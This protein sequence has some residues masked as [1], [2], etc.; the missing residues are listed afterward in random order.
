M[1]HKPTITKKGTELPLTDMK[2]KPYMPV[3]YRLV[4]F[5][6]EHPDWT[7]DTTMTHWT[8]TYAIVECS[9][10]NDQGRVIAVDRKY[11]GKHGFGA[12]V[13]KA[14]TGSIGRALALCG[15]GTQFEP[16][17]DEEGTELKDLVDSPIEKPGNSNDW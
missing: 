2:G 14:T 4:W 11:V 16:E 7:I 13:E 10:K 9:I 8:D 5:R 17:L 15:Y 12:Y 6:E 1:I 3:A